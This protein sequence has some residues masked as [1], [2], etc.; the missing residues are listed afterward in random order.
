MSTDLLPDHRAD[1]TAALHEL[2][3]ERWSPRGFDPG[4]ELSQADLS[5]LL[6]AA[7]W[8]P[9]AGNSQPWRFI[10]ARRGTAA[11]DSLSGLLAPGN[12]RWAPLAS[13]LVVAVAV[14]VDG[15]G[16]PAP[17]AHYDT[18]AAMAH[19]TVQAQSLG[20]SVHQMGGFDAAGVVREFGLGAELEPIAAAAIGRL[21]PDAAL[22]EDLFA[23]ER[24]PRTRRSV[25]EL[26][27]S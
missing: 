25:E 6:E 17:W 20:L 11:F 24:A 1:T 10:V 3:A 14:I 18:G 4:Y 23:R 5:A 13:V 2:L 12:Q 26:L 15:K 7:R 22:P 9:S 16:A 27:L 19:L 8:A 21:D